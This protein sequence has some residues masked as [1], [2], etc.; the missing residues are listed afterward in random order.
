MKLISINIELNKHY[1]T[2]LDFLKQ[3]NP[4]VICL[5]ELLGDD[6]ENFKKVLGKQGIFKP[7]TRIGEDLHLYE[8]EV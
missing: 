3:E 7:R 2:V 8:Y 4:D 5:Q 1:K 6:F